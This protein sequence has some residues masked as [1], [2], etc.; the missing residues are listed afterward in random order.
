MIIRMLLYIPFDRSFKRHFKI[1]KQ[2]K[3][4]KCR[5]LSSALYIVK[6]T[7]VNF[8]PSEAYNFIRARD[9]RLISSCY[10]EIN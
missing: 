3:S 9:L 5:S 10:L 7:K 2:H 6:P 8:R 1:M 4:I